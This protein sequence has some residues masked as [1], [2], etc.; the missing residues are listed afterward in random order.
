ML[1]TFPFFVRLKSSSSQDVIE[2]PQK[3]IWKPTQK[4]MTKAE[5]KTSVILEFI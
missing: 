3:I 2:A 4:W 1:G 5:E